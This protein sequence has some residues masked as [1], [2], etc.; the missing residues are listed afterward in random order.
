MIEEY[1]GKNATKAFD[2]VGHSSEAKSQLKACKIGE[3]AQV[4][5]SQ[6]E[7]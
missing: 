7:Q 2:E 4:T 5:F 1:A 6:Q 3:L